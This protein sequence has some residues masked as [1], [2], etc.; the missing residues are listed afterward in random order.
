MKHI[1][2]SI[3]VA[4]LVFSASNL[5]AQTDTL[6]FT[7]N[8]ETVNTSDEDFFIS[9]TFTKTENTLVWTQNTED[10]IDTTSFIITSTSGNWN[11][12]TSLG[13]VIY[14]LDSEG[15]QCELIL[16]GLESGI[17]A[18]IAFITETEQQDQYT[19]IIDTISYQ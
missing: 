18:I 16:T 15:Y 4:L 6:N 12:S 17:S 3:I 7:L 1:F 14:T 8:S 10:N 2:K 9:S 13:S 19:F 11:Q 5:N